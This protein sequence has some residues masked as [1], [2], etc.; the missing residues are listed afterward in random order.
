M[1]NLKL[2]LKKSRTIY[3]LITKTQLKYKS[4][5][6]LNLLNENNQNQYLIDG[7]TLINL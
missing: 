5:S 4:N 7:Q 1:Q 6:Q 3:N 2:P